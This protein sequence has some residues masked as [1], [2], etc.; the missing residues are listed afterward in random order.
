[1]KMYDLSSI[2]FSILVLCAWNHFSKRNH[3]HCP[4]VIRKLV[5]KA[6][7]DPCSNFE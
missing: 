1:M 7:K 5:F 6:K 2:Q 4:N 3:F